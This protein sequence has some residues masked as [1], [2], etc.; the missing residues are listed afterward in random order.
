MN[1]SAAFWP[2][3]L[4]LGVLASAFFAADR[5]FAHSELRRRLGDEFTQVQSSQDLA[6]RHPKV[7]ERKAVENTD[8]KSVVQLA[9]AKH[10]VVVA[11][12]NETERESGDKMNERNVVVRAVNVGHKN[13]VQFLAEIEQQGHGARLKD[14]RLKPAEDRVGLYQEAEAILALRIPRN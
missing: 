9:G 6:V 11:Y 12:L 7:F 4:S 13:F 2:T 10:G 5:Y 1:T 14:I 3:V 8:L